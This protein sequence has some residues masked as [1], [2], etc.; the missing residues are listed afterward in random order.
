AVRLGQDVVD[1]AGNEHVAHAGS[2]LDARAR[3]G[4]HQDDAAA[5]EAADNAVWNRLV[6]HLDF[7]LPPHGLLGILDCL[8]DGG[9]PRVGLAVAA[10]HSALLVADNDEGVE[11]EAPA[12]LD[13]GGTAPDL[14][15]SFFQSVLPRLAAITISCHAM[16]PSRAHGLQPAGVH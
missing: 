5:A 4:R 15:H 13:H 12:S 10:G 7:L 11:A 2:R 1:A 8:L 6:L 9:A 16:L 14:H 3:A